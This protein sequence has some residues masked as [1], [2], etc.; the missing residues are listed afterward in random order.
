[1]TVCRKKRIKG[2]R[3][4]DKTCRRG[5]AEAAVG[6]LFFAC[7]LDWNESFLGKARDQ[8]A[9][10]SQKLS[11]QIISDRSGR[12]FTPHRLNLNP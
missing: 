8:H 2:T 3:R 5:G 4:V 9:G 7:F 1:M 6:F 11:A 10:R 12:N